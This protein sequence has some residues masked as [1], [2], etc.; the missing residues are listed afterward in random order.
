MIKTRIS[1]KFVGQGEPVFVIAEAGVNHNGDV[2]LAKKLIDAA[3]YAGADAVKFQAFKTERLA[4]KY[5]EKANYQKATVT[6]S[7]TQFDMLKQLE[8]SDEDFKELTDYAKEKGIIFL[9]SAF[10]NESVDLLD[11][12]NV[13]AFKVSS[14][15][16]T[17]FPLIKYISK[18]NKPIILSTG[19]STFNEIAEALDVFQD[20][21][22]V[23]LLHCVTSYPAEIDSV[24]LLKIN[25]LRN[26]FGLQV[27]FSDH[28]I[29]SIAS[30]I[31][32][33]LG[34]VIIEKHFTLDKTLPGPDHKASIE[35][36]EFKAMITA[37]HDAQKALGDEHQTLAGEVAIK[38][39][40]R[41]SIVAR[42]PIPKGTIICEEMLDL[43]RPATGIEPK[44]LSKVVGKT[45]VADIALDEQI[46]FE[47]LS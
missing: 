21:K 27:G 40:V 14:G 44:Y 8:L 32:I 17:N 16:I 28:T 22:D 38:R 11:N 20:R 6:S 26:H 13:P 34:A 36:N 46:T 45:V 41:R 25:K 18:K 31:S 23:I 43:K 42:V 19:M 33:A 35:P 39:L 5:A 4:T 30:I 7:D 15:E 29:G 2:I 12:L 37:L 24:N 1:N 3:K 9:A 47:K 10:D